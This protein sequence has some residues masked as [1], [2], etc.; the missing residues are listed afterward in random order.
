VFLKKL[1]NF[2]RDYNYYFEKGNRYLADERFA[3]A[4]AAFGEAIELIEEC[5]DQNL[6][7]IST[8]REKFAKAGNMLGRLNLTEAEHAI[9][10]GDMKKA[11]DHLSIVMELA[12]DPN[13]RERAD[14]LMA[15][16][17]TEIHETI[18]AITA[19]NCG[20]CKGGES[21]AVHYDHS[22]DDTIPMEDRVALYFH[23]LPEDLPERYALMGEEFA[24]GCHLNLQGDGE[25]ALRV[26]EELS[27]NLDNDILD[28]EKAII[29][30]HKGD[31]GKCEL[32]L[33]NA[34]DLNRRNPLCHIGLVQ[35][36]IETGRAPEALPVLE[37]L[38]MDDLI[39]EQ[40]RLMEGDLHMLLE[41]ESNAVESYSKLLSSPRYAREAVERLVPLLERQGRSEEAKYL[42]SKYAKGCC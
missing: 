15:R 13:I 18:P 38:I 10:N 8:L 30:Y 41:N 11:G 17:G 7:M 26:F 6:L 1:F 22:M 20:T 40:A 31:A 29:Y 42:V 34:I 14:E 37:S 5:G 39:P 24:R 27:A 32:L 12:N 28:Y 36:Y 23:T 21:E 9:S 35:L 4:R 3:D 2:N 25:G 19:H 16:L 33:R